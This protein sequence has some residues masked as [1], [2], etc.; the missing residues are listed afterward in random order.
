M[1][2]GTEW[3]LAPVTNLAA[4]L[5]GGGLALLGSKWSM[6]T[7]TRQMKEEFKLERRQKRNSAWKACYF[8]ILS[9]LSSARKAEEATG[10]GKLVSFSN[11]HLQALLPYVSILEES[12]SKDLVSLSV[13]IGHHNSL[14]GYAL[15]LD[16]TIQS[17]VDK[18]IRDERARIIKL[19]ESVLPRYRDQSKLPGWPKSIAD[20]PN[21]EK[22]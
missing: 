22:S 10:F 4:A 2:S 5:V 6:D 14:V 11:N 12:L 15:T 16:H 18:P 17:S 21:W 19:V 1:I 13:S 8:E 9:V 20:R 7:S 3:W